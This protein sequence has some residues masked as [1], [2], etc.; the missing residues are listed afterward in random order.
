MA[1]SVSFRG[2]R[3]AKQMENRKQKKENMLGAR[4]GLAMI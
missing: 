1:V 3:R 4:R 2:D